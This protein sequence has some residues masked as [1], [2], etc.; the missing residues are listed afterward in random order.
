[1][2]VSGFAFAGYAAG[3]AAYLAVHNLNIS[4]PTTLAEVP[5]LSGS[6]NWEFRLHLVNCHQKQGCLK[7]MYTSQFVVQVAIGYDFCHD[8]RFY[9]YLCMYR[10]HISY[11]FGR[12]DKLILAIHAM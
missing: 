9:M 11:G 4:L 7:I 12:W 1:M 10:E 8:K 5:F 3:I 6:W 2:Q